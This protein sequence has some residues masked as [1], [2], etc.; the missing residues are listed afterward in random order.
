MLSGEQSNLSVP[1]NSQG[2][3]FRHDGESSARSHVSHCTY[4]VVLR[5]RKENGKGEGGSREPHNKKFETLTV[6]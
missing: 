1:E 3:G 6:E 5:A 4:C 2:I